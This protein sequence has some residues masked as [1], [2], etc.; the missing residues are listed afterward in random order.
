MRIGLFTDIYLPS[1]Y[2]IE[3]ATEGVRVTLE[4]MGHKVFVFAPETPGYVDA[5]RRVMRF[6]SKR[7]SKNPE[8]RFAFSFLPIGRSNREVLDF[9]LDIAQAQTM[10]AMGM[11]AR[12]IAQHQ[13]IPLLYAHH[14]MY[15]GYVGSESGDDLLVPSL[16]RTYTKWFAGKADAI[17]APTLKVKRLLAEW[18]M[19]CDIPVHVVPTGVDTAVFHRSAPARHRLRR[20]LGIPEGSPVLLTVARLVREKNLDFLL[21]AFHRIV[22][23]APGSRL[24]LVGEGNYREQLERRARKMGVASR[25]IF[26]GL[27]PH[28]RVAAYYQA[29]DLFVFPSVVESQGLVILEALA[30]G[31]PVVAVKDEAYERFVLDGRNGF[32]VQ[33]LTPARFAACTL[34][35]VRS[36]ALRSR[37]SRW[38][39]RVSREYTPEKTAGMLVDIYRATIRELHARKPRRR[40]EGGE[41]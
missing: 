14:S 11:L 25:T 32:L 40:V 29:A 2:G 15:P 38:A 22:R 27:V 36:P 5:S 26:A 19:G 21:D 1:V 24:L 41:R 16:V 9:R 35:L 37:A 31:L 17:L 34:P 33:P 4:E 7:I 30:S 3:L 13:G 12:R 6:R 18:G 28:E 39:R 8:S 23:A 10:G 20:S